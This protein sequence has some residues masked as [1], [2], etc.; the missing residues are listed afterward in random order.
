[1]RSDTFKNF[2][3]PSLRK[4]VPSPPKKASHRGLV[5]LVNW[6]ERVHLGWSHR[7]SSS[8]HN[9]RSSRT[10]L[11]DALHCTHGAQCLILGFFSPQPTGVFQVV[12]VRRGCSFHQVRRARNNGSVEPGL[13]KRC[14]TSHDEGS[15]VYGWECAA[16]LYSIRSTIVKGTHRFRNHKVQNT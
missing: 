11:L 10:Q 14:M 3:T 7:R 4:K 9:V 8:H 16:F 13:K 5:A 15:V 12:Q 1:M 6:V 2:L